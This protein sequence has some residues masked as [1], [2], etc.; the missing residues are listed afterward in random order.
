MLAA[1]SR[2]FFN[3]SSRRERSPSFTDIGKGVR[4][5]HRRAAEQVTLRLTVGQRDVGLTQC[6][7]PSL[8]LSCLSEQGGVR[9]L[10]PGG[11]DINLFR[12]CESIVD[13]DPQ[14]SD[15]TLDFRVAQ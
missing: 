11:S 3:R 8:A 12:Y 13:F 1:S 4:F 5:D 6:M 9:P 2:S 15:G 7:S 14:I 10:R